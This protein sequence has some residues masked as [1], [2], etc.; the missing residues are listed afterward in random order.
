MQNALDYSVAGAARCASLKATPVPASLLDGTYAAS[1]SG[2]TIPRRISPIAKPDLPDLGL[3]LSGL[4]EPLDVARH[5][6]DQPFGKLVVAGLLS[7]AADNKL[8]RHMRQAKGEHHE[9][10]PLIV[11]DRCVGFRRAPRPPRRR[12]GAIGRRAVRHRRLCRPRLGSGQLVLH[13]ARDAG[14]RRLGRCYA[15]AALSSATA[16]GATITGDQLRNAGRSVAA[17]FNFA[18]GTNSTTSPST[19][20]RH[21]HEPDRLLIAFHRIQLLMSRC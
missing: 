3:R 14:R 10:H 16:T 17:T 11:H 12:R 21:D 19:I 20:R 6:V 9:Q 7:A 15:A 18:N 8:P 4:R 13:D 2:A 5:P 1:L